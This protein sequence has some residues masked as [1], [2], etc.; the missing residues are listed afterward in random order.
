MRLSTTTAAIILL[1]STASA[2]LN[3]L[4]KSA[5]K[6]Y[7]GT[8]TDNSELSDEPYKAI[9]SNS[10]IFGAVT[11]GNGQKWQFTEPTQGTFSYDLGDEIVSLAET[12]Q[13]L[14]RCHTLV[15]HSQLPSWVSS[16]SWTTAQLT[17]IIQTHIENEVGHYQ[18][19][20]Y[21]WDV[22]N[23]ALNED[24]TFRD[25]V[26][27]TV[28]GTDFL[29]IAF[30]AAAAADPAAKLYYNDY[31]I[32]Q[33]GAKAQ[34][35]VD[36]VIPAIRDAGATIHG[37]GAQAHLIV[38]SVASRTDLAAVLQSFVDAGVD[39]VAYTELDI[40]HSSVPSTA[41]G[42]TQQANDYVNVVGACLDVEA[43]VGVTIWDFTDKY[44]WVP[45]VFDG[46]GEALLWDEDLQPKEAYTSVSSLLAAA[47]TAAA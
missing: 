18:G 24:G 46:A 31:N 38:G 10:S 5:G 47:A 6:L 9:L 27:H 42:R 8:A 35:V 28:L 2:S 34:A 17:D 36:T 3:T 12:N 16:G 23:E 11:P 33:A 22:V 4:A 15:W 30:K 39:E 7:F 13:Q 20:C 37:V 14:V 32:E 26:F 19:Q 21:A 43:C 41:D 29:G 1:P 40:R 44:S 25:S 45:S